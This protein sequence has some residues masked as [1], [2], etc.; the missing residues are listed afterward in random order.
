MLKKNQ[1]Y[2]SRFKHNDQGMIEF[3]TLVEQAD[4]PHRE[5]ILKA[6]EDEDPRFLATAMRRVVYFEELIYVDEMIL[7]EILSK[8]SPKVLAYALRG[9]AED[10]RQI[11]LKTL[12]YRELKVTRDEEEQ[13]R[14]DTPEALVLGARRQIL[15]IART[16]EAQ[17]K[18]VFEVLE[19]P[20]LARKRKKVAR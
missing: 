9:T 8:V 18:F 4:P 1:A 6:A 19:C 13:I 3:A 10:F 11:L 17:Q 14:Q 20:R 16:L 12:G 5:M 15:K 2:L 7:A